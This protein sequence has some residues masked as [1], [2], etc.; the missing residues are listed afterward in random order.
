MPGT[1]SR[2]TAKG[3]VSFRALL[4]P[5]VAAG[6][7]AR[8]AHGRPHHSSHRAHLPEQH[9]SWGRVHLWLRSRK[10]AFGSRQPKT[11]A[12]TFTATDQFR[13][14]IAQDGGR[15]AHDACRTSGR[16]SERKTKVGHALLRKR[17][18]F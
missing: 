6:A 16:R 1:H 8:F 11:L 7:T 4:G 18:G 9:G 10:M 13:H 17:R 14:R 2:W 15:K 12:A 3:S 5:R